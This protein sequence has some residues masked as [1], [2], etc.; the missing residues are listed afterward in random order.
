MKKIIFFLAF[1]MALSPAL[2]SA[3]TLGDKLQGKL[4]LQVEQRGRIWYVAPKDRKRYEVTFKNALPLFEQHAVGITN[5]NLAKIREASKYKDGND[6][7]KRFKGK[8]FLQVEDKGRIWYVDF[9]GLRHEVTWT[10]LLDLFKS[11]SLG[12]SNNDLNSITVGSAE[13]SDNATSSSH[14]MNDTSSANSSDTMDDSY[15]DSYDDSSYDS[16]YNDTSSYDNSYNNSYT[17]PVQQTTT[18]TKSPAMRLLTEFDA[19]SAAEIVQLYNSLSAND[20]LW[21]DINSAYTE[22]LQFKA[23]QE[24]PTFVVTSSAFGM[25]NCQQAIQ[26]L[27]TALQFSSMESVLQNADTQRLQILNAL[28]CS[29]GS[30]DSATCSTYAN[31]TQNVNNMV[32]DTNQRVLMNLNNECYLNVDAGC[33]YWNTY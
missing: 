11:L 17:A 5:A 27:Q 3:A 22:L 33:N 28:A 18:S 32:N 26:S 8:L 13:N 9:N 31:T 14:E 20:R 29:D 16:S 1:L 25:V 23:C 19:L 4:L 2:T 10:N 24:Y 12:I 30:I 21:F 6:F 15:D 7:G